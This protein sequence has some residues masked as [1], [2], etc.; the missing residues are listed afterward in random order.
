V[1][2]CLHDSGGFGAAP[3]HDAHMLYTVSGVQ[4]LATLDAFEDLEKH[5]PGGSQKIGRCAF[6]SRSKS[7][8]SYGAN[9][10]QISPACR[11]LRRAHLPATSGA[12][13]TRGSCMAHSMRCR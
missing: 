10:A 1:L 7:L 11:I 13:R 4:I 9:M 3:G 2:S 5:V 8:W 12:S 6:G